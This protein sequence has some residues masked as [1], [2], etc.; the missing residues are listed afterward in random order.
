MKTS[1]KIPVPVGTGGGE[2]NTAWG[3]GVGGCTGVVGGGGGLW[4]PQE[5]R[6]MG[7]FYKSTLSSQSTFTSAS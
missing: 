4:D 3:V 2:C 6:D 1:Q 7:W 5:E